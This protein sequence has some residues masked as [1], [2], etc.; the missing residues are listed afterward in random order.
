MMHCTSIRI[1]K[2]TSRET[3]TEA[4]RKMPPECIQGKDRHKNYNPPRRL[5]APAAVRARERVRDAEIVEAGRLL[6]VVDDTLCHEN[7]LIVERLS[8]QRR[9]ETADRT[10]R[11]DELVTT[12]A[13]SARI[14]AQLNVERRMHAFLS[15][16]MSREEKS[17]PDCKEAVS[18][19]HKAEEERDVARKE[20]DASR[21]RNRELRDEIEVLKEK[22]SCQLAQKED[23]LV[24]REKARVAAWRDVA[25]QQRPQRCTRERAGA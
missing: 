11:K 14:E 15:S 6:Q 4:S 20:R 13:H 17:L 1:G 21:A 25:A 10:K 8:E 9:I 24:P 7:Q 12:K 23:D 16:F 5:S 19:W 3:E 22:H 18:G 2:D